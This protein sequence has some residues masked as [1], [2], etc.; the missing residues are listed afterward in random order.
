MGF[1]L[2]AT[3]SMAMA[4]RDALQVSRHSFSFTAEPQI[5][6]SHVT[7]RS[8]ASS[9]GDTSSSVRIRINVKIVWKH[10]PWWQRWCF[11]IWP[12]IGQM[13]SFSQN[14][15]FDSEANSI[16]RSEMAKKNLFVRRGTFP[17]LSTFSAARD[18]FHWVS[19]PF[20]KGQLLR[21]HKEG[22]WKRHVTLLYYS[23]SVLNGGLTMFSFS[24]SSWANGGCSS[25]RFEQ[26]N[27]NH[28]RFL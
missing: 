20:P 7:H 24:N 6:L 1:A 9:F 4:A 11:S 18:S 3:P 21:I 26:K 23:A 14:L 27:K 16:L 15:V 13:A 8:C 25:L 2:F 22:G 10:V 19:F 28:W 12:L 5:F 17:L